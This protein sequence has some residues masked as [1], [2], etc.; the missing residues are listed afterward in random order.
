MVSW[1]LLTVHTIPAITLQL[2][3]GLYDGQRRPLI[4]KQTHTKKKSQFVTFRI[5]FSEKC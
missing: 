1:S 2:V 4:S 5:L 3:R